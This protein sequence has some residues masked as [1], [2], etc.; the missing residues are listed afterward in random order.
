MVKTIEEAV[1]QLRAGPDAPVRTR[2]GDLTI[3][4]S[5][6]AEPEPQRSAADV[7][8]ELGP[9]EGETTE[10]ILAILADAGAG[11]AGRAGCEIRP[12]FQYHHLR[13]NGVDAVLL[14]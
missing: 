12:R 2:V 3:E 7:F 13:L 11:P 9:W 5:A 14:S 6:V 10:E 1:E 4:V 8:A